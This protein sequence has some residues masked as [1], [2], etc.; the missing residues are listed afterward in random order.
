MFHI[1]FKFSIL[2]AEK[3]K[4]TDFYSFLNTIQQALHSPHEQFESIMVGKVE[5]AD[6]DRNDKLELSLRGQHA[7]LFE[8]D[9]KG[10]IYLR[11]EQ[12]QGLNESTVHLVA[13]ATD[14]GVPPRSTSVPVTVTMEK[15]ALAQ[16]S[17][18][19]SFIG[20]LGMIISVFIIVI[21]IL[22]CYIIHSKRKRRKGTPPLGRNR[23]HSHAHSTM[24][25]ANLVTHEKISNN[26]NGSVVTS[27]S[28]GVS[29]LHMKHDGNISMSNPIS[30]GLNHSG[31]GKVC[32]TILA[33]NLEREAKHDQ[34]HDRAKQ[35]ESYTAT[36]RSKFNFS[37]V[38]LNIAMSIISHSSRYSVSGI[39]Q[40][41]VV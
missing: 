16:T 28:S 22:T 27:G 31:V 26:G 7:G 38:F 32:S 40:W 12:L 14:S 15:I 41:A 29:V 11:L 4:C 5:A 8:I 34:E 18:S 17:W 23:V 25:S 37:T 36:V 2:L 13:T 3:S 39:C 20:M 10:C 30:S 9:S 6:G 19:S 33:T 21:I 35:R 24:S 1:Y